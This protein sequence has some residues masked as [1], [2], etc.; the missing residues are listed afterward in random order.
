MVVQNEETR[1]L[2]TQPEPFEVPLT[3]PHIFKKRR[4][5]TIN[6]RYIDCLDVQQQPAQIYSNQLL[7]NSKLDCFDLTLQ[8]P[9]LV[10]QHADRNN[11]TRYVA[12]AP[13]SRLG[14][15]EDVRNVLND[16][17]FRVPN[18]LS[19]TDLLFAQKRQMEEDFKRF[20]VGSK[21]DKLRNTAIQSFGCCRGISGSN[22]PSTMSSYLR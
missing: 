8:F 13:Q 5:S 7:L 21:H 4:L 15:D 3:S 9:L 19:N 14:R 18:K 1:W 16:N 17:E 2:L 11:R 20:G 10:G 6:Y 22:K 12:C